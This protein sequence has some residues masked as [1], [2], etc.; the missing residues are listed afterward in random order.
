MEREV[1]LSS[2]GME[3]VVDAA[4][5]RGISTAAGRYR[6]IANRSRKTRY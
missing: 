3:G 1:A 6:P 4:R 2:S 5:R